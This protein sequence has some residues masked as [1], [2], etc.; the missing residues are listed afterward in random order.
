MLLA[1]AQNNTRQSKH[2]RKVIKTVISHLLISML[3]FLLALEQKYSQK[4][5]EILTKIGLFIYF[6]LFSSTEM[7]WKSSPLRH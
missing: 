3:L 1:D 5:Y 4:I 6:Y 7:Y 2:S